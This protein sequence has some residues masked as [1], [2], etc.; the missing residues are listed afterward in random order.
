MVLAQGMASDPHRTAAHPDQLQRDLEAEA[1]SKLPL[2]SKA[3]LSS[4][5]P[6]IHVW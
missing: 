4:E 6:R 3:V 1:A 5:A 2:D